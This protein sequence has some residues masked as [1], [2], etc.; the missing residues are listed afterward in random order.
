MTIRDTLAH[1][2]AIS[3][4]CRVSSAVS[5]VCGKTLHI[6][7]FFDGFARNLE[8]DLRD[9]RIS[10]IG[11]LF[12][13]HQVDGQETPHVAFDVYRKFYFSGL[14][15]TYDASLGVQ[16]G[17]VINRAQSD[18]MDIPGDTATDQAL[19][20]AKDK[21]SGRSWWQR[22]KRD[23]QNLRDRPL[24]GLKVFKD[25]LVN[26]AVETVAPL[27]DSRWGAHMVK[28]GVE[29]RLEGALNRINREITILNDIGQMPLR[30]IKVSVF[31]FDFG[32]TLARAFV[33]ELLGR[34][35]QRDSEY[36]YSNA[37]LEIVFAGLFDAVD[38]SAAEL[39]P[40]EYA[41]PL[42]N[43]IDDGGLIH[44][45]VKAVLHLVAAHERRFYRRAR[46]LGARHRNWHEELM[47]GISEDIG[48]GLAPGEQ[49]A[50]NELALVSLHRMYRAAFAAGAALTP[51]QELP[52]KGRVISSLF[53]F[54]DKAPSQRSADALVRHYQRWL[55]NQPPGHEAFILHMRAYIRWLAHLWHAYKS[56]MAALSAQDDALHRSQYSDPWS[57]RSFLGLRTTTR[58]E[59]REILRKRSEIW[60]RQSE[61]QKQLGWLDEVDSEARSIKNRQQVYGARAAGTRQRL[62]VWQA[63]LSEWS[64]PQPLPAE[65]AELFSFFVH[66]QVVLSAAQR[67]A[68]GLS[69]ENFFTIR[70]FDR[71]R[72]QLPEEQRESA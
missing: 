58:A 14:G 52:S 30:T 34:C 46:L 8:E 71:P 70:G 35:Q 41:L 54:N 42:T 3:S 50:S 7:F 20:G 23:L 43:R 39:P 24:T 66:D 56:E 37:R 65:V 33:H 17:G 67:S 59:D 19:E 11:K 6:G 60:R 69:G 10:N 57:M 36:Y 68:R 44:P 1:A 22:L 26:T 15:A 51:L 47:P 61:L 9:N 53:V 29:V 5:P 40:L 27:R 62:E 31:G 72:G 16:A 13:A 12:L 45:E 63:L 18:V 55:G 21:L 4:R 2:Q 32:A 49:K 28:S 48:G 38:R 25:M 64:A